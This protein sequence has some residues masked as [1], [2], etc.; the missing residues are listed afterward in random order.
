MLWKISQL[1]HEYDHQWRGNDFSHCII[2]NPE[3]LAATLTH[4]RT[5][6]LLSRQTILLTTS[7][8]CPEHKHQQSIND[9]YL[10]L[11]ENARAA[12]EH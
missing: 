5:I 4:N 12:W 3:A 2:D 1:P 9:F 8:L 11:M 10:C 7:G 6:A